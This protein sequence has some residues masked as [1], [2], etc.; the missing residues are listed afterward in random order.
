MNTL[1]VIRKPLRYPRGYST[2]M[3]MPGETFQALKPLDERALLL[4]KRVVVER[5]MADIPPPPKEVV[6][7]AS[8]IADLRAEYEEVFGKKPFNGWSADTL[9]AKLAEA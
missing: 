3:M 4:S 1:R 8:G 5:P 6:A 2:R 7:K 9:A